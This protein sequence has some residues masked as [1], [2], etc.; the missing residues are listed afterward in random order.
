MTDDT[1]EPSAQPQENQEAKLYIGNLP[2]STTSEDLAT[3]FA[4]YQI[5]EGSAIII[6]DRDDPK[7]SKGFG[8]VTLVNADDVQKAIDEKNGADMGGRQVVVSKAR[9]REERPQRERR[10]AQGNFN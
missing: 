6:Y 7:K 4:E 3:M 9:P 8:F 5:V 1:M 2:F 10:F